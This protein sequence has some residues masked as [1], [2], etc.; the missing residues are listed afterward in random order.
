MAIPKYW[1]VMVKGGRKA[2]LTAF[3]PGEASGNLALCGRILPE[4]ARTRGSSRTISEPDGDECDRCR[5]VSGNL[6]KPKRELT[7]EQRHEIERYRAIAIMPKL[8]RELG[9]NDSDARALMESVL[10]QAMRRDS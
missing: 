10:Q 7:K 8:L 3:I 5:V 1:R 4:D 9:L 6:K 2:H